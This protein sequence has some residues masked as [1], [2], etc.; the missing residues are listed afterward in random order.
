[1]V[2]AEQGAGRVEHA[3]GVQ[4]AHQ[5]Q[6][7]A[8]GVGEPGHGAGRVRGGAGRDGEDRS[9]GADRDDDVALAG[10]DSQRRGRVV[11]GARP[12]RP[13]AGRARRLGRAEDLWQCGVLAER[14]L[15]QVAAVSPGGRGPVA[16][17]AGVAAVGAQACEVARAGQPPG[18]PV[19]GQAHCRRPLGRGGLVLGEPA[20]LRHGER[21]DRHR[22]DGVRPPL[23]AARQFGD[24]VVRRAGGPGVVPQQGRP[25]H[26][27][28]LVQAHHAVLLG[29]DGDRRGVVQPAGVVDRGAQRRPPRVRMDL[30]AVRMRRPALPDV[31]AGLRVADDDLAGLRRRVDAGHQGHDRAP[32][33]CSTA[34]WLRCTKP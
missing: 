16:R 31:G 17:A 21:G 24:E 5:R 11:P 13:A 12:E 32:V 25:Y 9:G 19:V 26:L 1:M 30:G 14:H 34:S 4:G 28:R 7:P 33:R 6:E 8:G 23:G 3:G 27:A 20:E 10:A 18:E 2:D 29:G 15:E 22:A